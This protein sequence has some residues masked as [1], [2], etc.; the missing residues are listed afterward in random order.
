MARC[1]ASDSIITVYDNDRGYD[2]IANVLN[3]YPNNGILVIIVNT[4]LNNKGPVRQLLNKNKSKYCKI[5][6]SSKKYH[7]YCDVRTKLSINRT[8][9]F[10]TDKTVSHIKTFITLV[11]FDD[12]FN[13]HIKITLDCDNSHS[14]K[15]GFNSTRNIE[16]VFRDTFDNF[17]TIFGATMVVAGIS[18]FLLSVLMKKSN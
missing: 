10:S 9:V 2:T 15:V 1:T 8:P 6:G 17:E 7:I 14:C 4:V 13:E 18:G 12:Y 16:Q 3:R 5:Y 11:Y